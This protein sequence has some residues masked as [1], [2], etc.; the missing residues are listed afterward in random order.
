M[1]PD[2][3]TASTANVYKKIGSR[4]FSE[5]QKDKKGEKVVDAD[6]EV[7]NDNK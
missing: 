5:E 1:Y 6:F 4:P 7:I 3:K 2:S